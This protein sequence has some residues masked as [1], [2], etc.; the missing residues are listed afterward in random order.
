MM[1]SPF[2]LLWGPYHAKEA[3]DLPRCLWKRGL[4]APLISLLGLSPGAKPTKPNQFHS[5]FC[6]KYFCSLAAAHLLITPPLSSRPVWFVLSC[7]AFRQ[8]SCLLLHTSSFVIIWAAAYPVNLYMTHHYAYLAKMKI[9]NSL[10]QFDFIIKM[11]Q[12]P[13]GTVR[14]GKS[15]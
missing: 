11:Y 6:A 7:L 5:N 3:L 4:C 12:D 8:S 10:W 14:L 9:C 1:P 15:S 2:M 13:S